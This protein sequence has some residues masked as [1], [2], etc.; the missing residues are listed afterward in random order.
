M[1][2]HSS[3]QLLCLVCMLS[4]SVMSYSATSWTV[5]HQAYLSM[6]FSRQEYWSRLPSPSPGDLPNPGIKQH[7]QSDSLQLSHQGRQFRFL[8]SISAQLK[9]SISSSWICLSYIWKSLYTQSLLYMILVSYQF[10][11][12]QCLYGMSFLI[13]LPFHVIIKLHF[14][15]LTFEFHIIFSL[16]FSSF[17]PVT[18]ENL[19]L[20][21]GPYKNKQCAKLS[22]T[23][24]CSA[25]QNK[26]NPVY[27]AGFKIQSSFLFAHL[28]FIDYSNWEKCCKVAKINNTSESESS[29]VSNCLWPHG[30]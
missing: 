28:V 25:I 11:H 13:F 21:W 23:W 20:A 16:I 12:P 30:L 8:S 18:M 17:D 7:W 24:H 26:L 5:A 3:L 27:N 2:P 9:M 19:F 10:Y 14:C 4:H 15:F 1:M 22:I 6:G 29:V